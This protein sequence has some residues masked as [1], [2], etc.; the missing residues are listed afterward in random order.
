[1]PSASLIFSPDVRRRYL[2]ATV[3]A[4][5]CIVV[6]A[7]CSNST[8][9]KTA[10]TTGSSTTPIETSLP[11]ATTY[12]MPPIT[13]PG[14]AGTTEYGFA[15]LDNSRARLSDYT[16]EVVV[17]DFY[18]TWCPPCREQVPHLIRLD[19]KYREQGL[20]IIGLNIGGDADQA[21]VPAFVEE[22][23]IQYQ[24]GDPDD[25]MA[26]LFLSDDGSIPQTY[27]FDRQNN[28]VKR[29][30]GYDQAMPAELERIIQTALAVAIAK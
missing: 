18:A 27:V 25:E 23:N 29:F 9:S 1:M 13:E 20:R 8:S 14:R 30:I 28:L 26:E 11:R 21:K 17:L 3:C 7:G 12:P 24:L 19:K 10:T 6:F 16:G 22:F 4:A 5:L 2:T 15:L